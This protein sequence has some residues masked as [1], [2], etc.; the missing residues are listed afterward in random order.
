VYVDKLILESSGLFTEEDLF[1]YRISIAR[2]KFQT[3]RTITKID[4]ATNITKILTE[5]D[6]EE[7]QNYLKKQIERAKQNPRMKRRRLEK[8]LEN[9]QKLKNQ[10]ENENVKCLKA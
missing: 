7:L 10:N 9:L 2:Y 5:I 1:V 3:K 6:L 4:P 8:F